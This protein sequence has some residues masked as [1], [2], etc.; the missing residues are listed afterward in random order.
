VIGA[1]QALEALKVL[2]G[3][4][5]GLAGRL[6]IFDGRRSE[7]RSIGLRQDPDCPVC[8]ARPVPA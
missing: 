3:I 2:L 4:E 5:T 6:L 8:Q 1:M 7:W